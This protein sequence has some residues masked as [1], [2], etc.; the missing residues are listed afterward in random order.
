MFLSVNNYF[1]FRN[2]SMSDLLLNKKNVW[3][4]YLGYNFVILPNLLFTKIY[5]KWANFIAN[6]HC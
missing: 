3:S 5:S 1:V 6:I 2:F 4:T